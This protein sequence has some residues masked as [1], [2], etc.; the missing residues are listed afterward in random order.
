MRI[1]YLFIF[2]LFSID[3]LALPITPNSYHFQAIP[4]SS[5]PCNATTGGAT[6]SF[7]SDTGSAS[8]SPDVVLHNIGV[9]P[10][11]FEIGLS[12][13]IASMSN[14][15]VINPGEATLYSKYQ[16]DTISCIT[17]SGSATLIATPGTGN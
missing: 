2:S 12:S 4:N 5:V 14:S 8:L 1:F 10:V 17:S 9:V 13:A 6:A 3:A 16:S 7:G 11:Y 15:N